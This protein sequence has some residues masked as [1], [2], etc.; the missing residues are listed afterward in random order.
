MKCCRIKISFVLYMC[1]VIINILWTYSFTSEPG[2]NLEG[3][4]SAFCCGKERRYFWMQTMVWNGWE[5]I[6]LILDDSIY[7]EWVA[8]WMKKKDVHQNHHHVAL[9]ML[10]FM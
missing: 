8:L 2:Y 7:Y 9:L 6:I 1:I 10:L 5:K 3:P 4:T